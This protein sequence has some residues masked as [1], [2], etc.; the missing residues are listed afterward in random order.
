MT[1]S[2]K[3]ILFSLIPV[4]CFYLLEF[5]QHNPFQEVRTEAQLFNIFLLELTAWTLFFLAG[6]AV[7]ALRIELVAVMIFGLVNHYVME[8]RSTPFVPWD[9]LSVNTAASVAG[10]Y[11][12][13]PS[14]R[15][16]LVSILFLALIFCVRFLRFR[17][18]WKLYAR[19]ISA[20][21]VVLVL[22]VF[23]NAL[24]ND[25]FKTKHYLYP[26]L[27]TPAYMTQVNGMLV[28]FAMNLEY[29]AVD[30]PADYHAEDAKE[31]LET[32]ESADAADN[33]EDL[34]NIIVIMDE[35]FSDLSVVGDFEPNEDYMPFVHSL[36]QG[37]DNTVTGYLNVSVCGGNTANTEFE[38]L[39]G[40]T[41]AFLP[42]GS[43][44]YQQYIKSETPS[45]AEYLSGLGYETYGMHPYNASGWD[46]DRV[47]PLLGF[48]NTRFFDDFT[49][50]TFL[51]KYVSD[52]SDFKNIIQT[53]EQKDEGHPAFIF[54]VTMQNH[55][56]YTDAY[57]NFTPD[58]TVTGTDSFVLE[59]YLSL[60]KRTDQAL[61]NLIDYFAGQKEKTIIVFFGDHQPA[62]SVAA[63]VLA[64]NGKDVN[65][66]NSEDQRLRYQVP[67]V[68]WANYDIEEGTGEDTSANYLAAR[69]LQ[70]A[71]VPTSAYQN[72]LLELE[73]DYPVISAVR[74]EKADGTETNSKEEKKGLLQYQQLQYYSLFDEKED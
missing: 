44:P 18:E 62:D 2:G 16:I 41:M 65:S 30:R 74:V 23:V 35:A 27:F 60:I 68:I 47:Y 43:I 31:T 37:N 49:D 28:T 42:A 10:N 56:S 67:Y 40:N 36:E 14:G 57:N 48:E 20:A 51:R 72:Y 12:F 1:V 71:G 69:V 21:L 25:D 38:F 4:I 59:Q 26:F 22:C 73:K 6:R 9:I 19:M 17:S 8:F 54:N 45:L 64:L 46:R 66:L 63:P 3:A 70:T 34:P 61:E 7:L 29:I 33:T 55:G 52:D 11:D 15:V 50:K 58:V 5:Y 13:T 53:Y 39:T 24:Q 32:Y